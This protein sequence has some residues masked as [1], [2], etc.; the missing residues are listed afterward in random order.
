MWCMTVYNEDQS[1]HPAICTNLPGLRLEMLL[2]IFHAKF[3]VHLSTF[4]D[5]KY[6]FI[7]ASGEATIRIFRVIWF[8]MNI[9]CPY[10]EWRYHLTCSVSCFKDRYKF[11]VSIWSGC[12]FC[13]SSY[14][15][16][17]LDW[18][19]TH[20]DSFFISIPNIGLLNLQSAYEVGQLS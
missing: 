12:W 13:T 11:P 7:P 8:S 18:L 3:N 19:S 5:S 9:S 1:L 10:N 4:R 14:N 20:S 2:H 15:Y 16:F 17:G 6:T